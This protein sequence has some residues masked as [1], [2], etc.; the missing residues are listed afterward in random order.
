MEWVRNNVNVV[1]YCNLILLVGGRG[2]VFVLSRVTGG[3]TVDTAG[4]EDKI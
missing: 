1:N 4:S 2:H 3:D